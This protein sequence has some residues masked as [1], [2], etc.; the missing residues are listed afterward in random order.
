MISRNSKKFSTEENQRAII[1]GSLLGESFFTR[2]MV[3]R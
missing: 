3:S 2:N 1:F